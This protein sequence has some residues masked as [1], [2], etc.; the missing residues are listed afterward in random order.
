[1][2]KNTDKHPRI[3]NR[4]KNGKKLR[5]R[6]RGEKGTRPTPLRISTKGK[7]KLLKSHMGECKRTKN[8]HHQ[9]GGEKEGKILAKACAKEGK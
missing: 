2:E 4:E 7:T 9:R 8:T 1:V 6:G 5:V 3:E